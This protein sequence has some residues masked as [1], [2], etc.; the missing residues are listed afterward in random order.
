MRRMLSLTLEPL[1]VYALI[2]QE[3]ARWTIDIIEAIT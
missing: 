3:S 1:R 2:V